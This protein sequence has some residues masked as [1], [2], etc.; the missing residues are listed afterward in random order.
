MT[1]K[2]SGFC[3]VWEKPWNWKKKISSTLPLEE[4]V[5]YNDRSTFLSPVR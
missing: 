4:A 5:G 1:K 3:T 2:L